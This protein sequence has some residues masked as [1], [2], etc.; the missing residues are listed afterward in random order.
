MGDVTSTGDVAHAMERGH[1]R[2]TRPALLL[3]IILT[4]LIVIVAAGAWITGYRLN[5]Q[6]ASVPVPPPSASPVAVVRSYVSA[7]NHRDFATMNALYPNMRRF[8]ES[9]RY[10]ALGTMN[11][12]QIT[13]SRHDVSYGKHSPYW[14]VGVEVN[15]TGLRWS[16]LADQPGHTGWDYNLQRIGPDHA[17]RIVDQGVG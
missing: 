16:D 17:W 9:Y 7:Y 13:D 5:F 2:R 11:D 10:R 4:V 1:A 15:F 6:T 3:L 8:H 14:M 12:L